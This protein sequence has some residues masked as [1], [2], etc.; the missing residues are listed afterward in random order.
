MGLHRTFVESPSRSPYAATAMMRDRWQ[1][2][3]RLYHAALALG[4]A[5]GLMLRPEAF[6]EGSR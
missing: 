6:A 1:Q 4:V 3:S 5:L 2:I